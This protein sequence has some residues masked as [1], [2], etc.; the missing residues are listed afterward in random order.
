M[1]GQGIC[2]LSLCVNSLK[3]EG[4]ELT[5]LLVLEI[6]PIARL[7]QYGSPCTAVHEGILHCGVMKL[8]LE[9]SA[10]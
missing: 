10:V 6:S 8:R 2:L 4:F 5:V 3:R 1:H 7:S 9:L